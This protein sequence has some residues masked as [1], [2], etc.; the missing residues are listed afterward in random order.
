MDKDFTIITPLQKRKCRRIIHGS[1]L[2]GGLVASGLAQL[3]ASDNAILVPLEII[4]VLALGQVFGIR[5]RHSYRTSLVLTTAATM[6]G[7]A[8]SEF[9]LGWIPVVGNL[10]D[11]LTA[12][13]VI[14]GLG[15]M[16][17][18]EFKRLEIP[19]K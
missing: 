8:V 4:M 11:A 13:A 6:I 12:I 1:A 5:L 10:F 18:K 15:W 3:P 9:L 14:E 16:V 2:I 19:L 17:T 7:R